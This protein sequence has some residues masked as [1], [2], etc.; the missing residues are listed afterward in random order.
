MAQSKKI[1]KKK[2]KPFEY[3]VLVPPIP[4]W[5]KRSDD[6]RSISI[7]DLPKPQLKQIGRAYLNNL[8]EFRKKGINGKFILGI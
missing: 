7:H 8:M 6:P 2:A 3:S 5:F 1:K 4:D